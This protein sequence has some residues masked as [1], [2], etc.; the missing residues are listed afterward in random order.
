MSYRHRPLNRISGKKGKIGKGN[1][2]DYRKNGNVPKD[3]TF[4]NYLRELRFKANLPITKVGQLLGYSSGQ[5][6]SNWEREISMPPPRK[7]KKLASLYKVSEAI[8]MEK[9]LAFKMIRLERSVLL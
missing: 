1:F 3:R 8:F 5:F 7:V 4:G 6:I 2:I 9:Y